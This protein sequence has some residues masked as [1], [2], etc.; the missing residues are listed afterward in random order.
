MTGNKVEYHSITFKRITHF[1][2]ETAGTF[3]LDA[4]L[5]IWIVGTARHFKRRVADTTV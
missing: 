2:I 4:E 3:E 1:S 5:K